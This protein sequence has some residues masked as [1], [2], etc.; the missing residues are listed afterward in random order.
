MRLPPLPILSLAL[1]ALLAGCNKEGDQSGKPA[2]ANAAAK[3]ATGTT[4]PTSVP[5]APAP[6][7]GMA[8]ENYKGVT[9]QYP[10]DWAAKK[11][12]G[13]EEGLEVTS[14]AIEGDWQASVLLRVLNGVEGQSL[15][16]AVDQTAQSAIVRKVATGEVR[17]KLL[18]HPAGFPYGQIDYAR[19]VQDIPLTQRELLIPMSGVQQLVVKASSSTGAWSKNEPVFNKIVESIRLP[20]EAK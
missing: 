9:F 13:E 17:V 8:S 4:K 16:E 11:I 18:T 7:A 2:D 19:S 3:P 10:K 6:A 1:L 5:S 20:K 14:P 12:E 15:A